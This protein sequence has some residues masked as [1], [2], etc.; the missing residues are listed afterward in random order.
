MITKV[1]SL[2]LAEKVLEDVISQVGDSVDA[3]VSCFEEGKE[4]GFEVVSGDKSV[5][6][7]QD[8]DSE[9]VVVYRGNPKHHLSKYDRHV[10]AEETAVEE[11]VNYLNG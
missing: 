7:A 1:A 5:I 3:Q 8:K 9:S 4:Q 2:I 11:V 10:Y 6:F